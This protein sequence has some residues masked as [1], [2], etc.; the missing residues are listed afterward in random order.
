MENKDTIFSLA[1]TSFTRADEAA[2][3]VDRAL[4]LLDY[5]SNQELC[6]HQEVYERM[7]KEELLDTVRT[8][9]EMV[10]TV[11]DVL[12][13][14]QKELKAATEHSEKY[15]E[16]WRSMKEA[17]NEAPA[18]QVTES[19]CRIGTDVVA[20][21]AECLASVAFFLH[22]GIAE[23]GS[24]ANEAETEQAVYVLR[25]L[26]DAHAQKAREAAGLEAQQ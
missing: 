26:I 25:N 13:S 6:S 24:P 8:A 23:G 17:A 9:Q 14:A 3:Y 5:L 20:F 18:P 1:H 7:P 10:F 19:K 21:D 16:Q 11:F 2:V 15:L 22:Q 4:F 12:I